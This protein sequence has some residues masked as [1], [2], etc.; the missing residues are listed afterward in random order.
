[1]QSNQQQSG[2]APGSNRTITDQPALQ[3]VGLNTHVE[4]DLLDEQG[5]AERLAF[6]LVAENAADIA[7]GR[8]G[9]NTPLG[10]VIRGKRVGSEVAY[11]MGDIRRVRIVSV[12]PVVA[13]PSDDAIA[14][15]QTI[16]DE[17]RRKS[18]RTNADMFAS[19]FS[20]KW[21]DYN[22]DEMKE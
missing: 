17:A 2:E 22:T 15:R 6:D 21:G 16:L 13:S 18:E 14:R 11:A 3:Q 12:R 20:G 19:S 10:K 4:V 1:M 8:L 7:Q 9:V 5:N